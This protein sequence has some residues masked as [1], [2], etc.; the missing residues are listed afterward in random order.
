MTEAAPV[1]PADAGLAH[2]H[3]FRPLSPRSPERQ[4]LLVSV[5]REDTAAWP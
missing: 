5:R 2:Q 3:G 1:L 4:V